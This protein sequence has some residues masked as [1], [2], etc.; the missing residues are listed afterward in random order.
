MTTEQFNVEALVEYAREIQPRIR[1][2]EDKKQELK[3]YKEGNEEVVNMQ[4][5]VK[6]A[7]QALA[8]HLEKDDTI[9]ELTAEIKDLSKELTQALKAASKGVNKKYK[10]KEFKAFF[11]AKV[12]EKVQP[13]VEK[14]QLF[15]EIESKLAQAAV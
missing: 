7:Q 9:R 6:D 5:A 11:T 8:L 13:T 10:P 1:E 2:I 12:K 15:S 4:Q 3:D 14:G